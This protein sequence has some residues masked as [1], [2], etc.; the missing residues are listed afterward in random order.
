M[1]TV[2]I[3]NMEYVVSTILIGLRLILDLMQIKANSLSYIATIVMYL[4]YMYCI[5]PNKKN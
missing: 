5:R 2:M 4:G 3:L 1:V